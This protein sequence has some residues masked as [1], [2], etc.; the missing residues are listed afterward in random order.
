MINYTYGVLKGNVAIPESAIGYRYSNALADSGQLSALRELYKLDTLDLPF[1]L[2]FYIKLLRCSSYW[3]N[4]EKTYDPQNTYS[5][6]VI[7]PK[8]ITAYRTPE[9][10]RILVDW[11]S[12]HS[13]KSALF[14][15]TQLDPLPYRVSAKI[16]TILT[17]NKAFD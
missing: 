7:K 9:I 15:Y 14:K 3:P 1:A 13:P 11:D 16:L 8:Y 2:D 10:G 4:Y 17:Q 12:K 6:E 5:I